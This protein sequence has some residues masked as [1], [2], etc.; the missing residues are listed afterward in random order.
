MKLKELKNLFALDLLLVL[1]CKNG[2][3][4]IATPCTIP[5]ELEEMLVVNISIHSARKALLLILED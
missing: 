3:T 5:E 2:E 1:Y 4:A